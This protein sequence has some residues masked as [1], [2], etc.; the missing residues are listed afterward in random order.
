MS[1]DVRDDLEDMEW[2]ANAQYEAHS[3]R[4]TSKEDVDTLHNAVAEIDRLRSENAELQQDVKRVEF[5]E[6]G[7]EIAHGPCS[8]DW[9]VKHRNRYGFG[10]TLRDA[11]DELME[12]LEV[13]ND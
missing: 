11:I 3:T 9:S 5:I 8:G 6:Q 7:V 10:D 4:K 12:N 13:A 2:V 1:K